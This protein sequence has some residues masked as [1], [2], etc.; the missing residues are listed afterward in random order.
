ML[1]YG[2]EELKNYG[3]LSRGGGKSVLLNQVK[4]DERV[5]KESLASGDSCKQYNVEVGGR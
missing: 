5:T 2:M 4:G 3:R 1:A